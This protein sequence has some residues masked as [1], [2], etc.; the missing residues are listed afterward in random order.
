MTE[1]KTIYIAH[2][3][4]DDSI[5]RQSKALAQFF[6]IKNKVVFLSAKK[7][8]NHGKEINKNLT[9]YEWPGKRPTGI[10]DFLFALQLMRKQKP[11]I[12]I[13]NYAAVNVLL[14]A[15]WLMEVP[16]RIC[17]FHTLVQQYI[18]D[19]GRLG[20]LQRVNIE[21]KKIVYAGATKIIAVSSAAKKDLLHYYHVPE[22]KI[23][24]F[25]NALMP[26]TA[27][28]QSHQMTV[29]FIGRLDASK[30]CDVLIKAFEKVVQQIPQA[31]LLIAGKGS[32]ENEL[33]QLA[34]ALKLHSNISFIGYVAPAKIFEFL[35]SLNCLAVPS[36]IDNLPSVVLEAFSTAT[37]VV[38][39]NAGGI[40]DMV[41]HGFN[42]LLF[43]SGNINDLAEKILMLLQQTELR[44]EI[45]KNALKSFEEKFSIATLPERFEADV[46][47]AE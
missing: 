36:R 33:Q 12:V 16:Q 47:N 27:R 11:D 32:K 44:N 24:V 3:W 18:A 26:Q 4:T 9:L 8:G 31:K 6:S 46:L 7:N 43:E 20:F 2:N 19:K 14:L 34:Q 22:K 41:Q 1:G 21:R 35:V 29:G 5:C 39:S 37:P 10:K 30:G 17:Y 25:P 28:N 42:G 13:A 23:I 38:A 15:A 40:T 45:S